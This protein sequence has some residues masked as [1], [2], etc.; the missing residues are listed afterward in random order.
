MISRSRCL[1]L[2]TI[3]TACGGAAAGAQQP[4][5]SG[6]DDLGRA[7]IYEVAPQQR[8]EA[9][10]ETGFVEV[11]GWGSVSVSPDRAVVSFAVETREESAGE[12]ASG[13]AE[14]MDAVL[15][16]LRAAG[17]AGLVLETHGYSLQPE[18]AMVE[19]GNRR[20]RVI[21]GYAAVNNVRASLEDM[22]AVGRVIDIAIG[23]GANRVAGLNFVASETGA[24]RQDALSMAV[25]HA[26]GEAAT[27]AAA[28]GHELGAVLEVRGGS[29]VP[30]PRGEQ[31]MLRAAAMATETPVEA[32][33]QTITASVTIKFAL[34]PRRGGR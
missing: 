26:R 10:Q 29:A 33:D 20:V 16:S 34:G 28:L 6:A 17:L 12:A 8:A 1:P 25:E 13:N 27:M 5:P 19:E 23:A 9:Q 24:A 4:S 7:H 22:D 3:L 15:T 30:R 11:S 31:I 18:Y 14:I 21:E 32:A 2:L